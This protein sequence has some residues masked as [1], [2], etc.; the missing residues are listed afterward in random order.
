VRV[1]NLEVENW[2]EGKYFVGASIRDRR[3]NI[4]CDVLTVYGP[5]DHEW[6]LEFLAEL[7]NRC[8]VMSLPIIFWGDFNL[9]RCASDKSMG[10]GDQRLMDVFN[11]FIEKYSLREMYRGGR[12]ILDK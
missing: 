9:I 5:A 3:T 11:T 6:S 1:D 10:V 12:N 2:E 8:N 7:E 4:R